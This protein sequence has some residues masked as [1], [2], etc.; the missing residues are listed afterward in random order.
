MVL[1]YDLG[2]IFKLPVG[3][4]QLS[5]ATPMLRH[6]KVIIFA[7]VAHGLE[8]LIEFKAYLYLFFG[9]G[10]A[11]QLIGARF[12]ILLIDTQF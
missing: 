6:G 10:I 7:K 5:S 11:N 9:D 8:R 12:L 3:K 4:E 2:R 1:F